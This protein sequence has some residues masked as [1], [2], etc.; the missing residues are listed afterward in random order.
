VAGTVQADQSPQTA[1]YLISGKVTAVHP[2][3]ETTGEDEPWR[4]AFDLQLNGDLTAQVLIDAGTA[5]LHPPGLG[6]AR[7][8]EDGAE[9]EVL[10]AAATVF[11]DDP[12]TADY[13]HASPQLHQLRARVVAAGPDRGEL[14]HRAIK[15]LKAHPAPRRSLAELAQ[16]EELPQGMRLSLGQ[17]PDGPRLTV[18][19]KVPQPLRLFGLLMF[20]WAATFMLGGAV[21]ASEYGRDGVLPWIKGVAMLLPLPPLVLLWRWLARTVIQLDSARLVMRRPLGLF[22]RGFC[23]PAVEVR[24]L[25]ELQGYLTYGLL[26]ERTSG[27]QLQLLTGAPEHTEFLRPLLVSALQALGYP[28]ADAGDLTRADRRS[29]WQRRAPF[30][31]LLAVLLSPLTCTVWPGLQLVCNGSAVRSAMHQA[32]QCPLVTKHLGQDLTWA[33]G[34]NQRSANEKE[35]SLQI[36]GDRG[37][38]E[39]HFQYGGADE[40]PWFRFITVTGDGRTIAAQRCAYY[41]E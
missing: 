33:V 28:A 37:R 2:Q 29:P 9:V 34:C 39:I 21:M 35:I 1:L 27:E 41:G 36:K 7:L 32:G 11:G 10:G 13:R 38:G 3:A 17:G 18:V 26:L 6:P 19:C 20:L 5:M 40:D 30:I 15:E 4:Q 22:R 12:Q 8:M 14:M 16:Q 23:V 24:Q 25:F 31:G